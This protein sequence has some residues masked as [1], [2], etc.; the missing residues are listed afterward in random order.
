MSVID[1]AARSDVSWLAK[2]GKLDTADL[3]QLPKVDF[4]PDLIHTIK[5]YEVFRVGAAI[6]EG[7]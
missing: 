7:V 2:L 1:H 5:L 4:S 6:F 3:F